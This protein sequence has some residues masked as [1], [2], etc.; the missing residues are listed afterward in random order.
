M[1]T[2]QAP[3][4]V[5]TETAV[6]FE[7]IT[8]LAICLLDLLSTIW[9]IAAG[10]A[11]EANPMMA[12]LMKHSLVLFCGV[13]M[14]TALCLVALTEWY[15]RYNPVFVRKVMRTAIAA[16]LMLYIVLVFSINLA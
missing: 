5:Q 9:L 13:K 1:K 15:R 3:A 2:T 11:T 7:S 8:V 16:Y 10:L 12:S 14:G 4:A 6:S